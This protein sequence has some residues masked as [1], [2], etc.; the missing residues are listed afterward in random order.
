MKKTK[1]QKPLTPL[2]KANAQLRLEQ[3]RIETLKGD[4]R[5]AQNRKETEQ[6]RATAAEAELVL[7]RRM[8]E[9]LHGELQNFP[10]NAGSVESHHMIGTAQGVIRGVMAYINRNNSDH[11]KKRYM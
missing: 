4:L 2:Q 11:F 10:N 1:K 7:V 9:E 8:L 6:A 5:I 3:E